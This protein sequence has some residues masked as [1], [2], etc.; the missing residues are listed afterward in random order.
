[1]EHRKQEQL[2]HEILR[3][4]LN[5]HFIDN[6]LNSV[7]NLVSM[8]D[9]LKVNQYLSDFSRL[10]RLFLNN[11]NQEFIPFK[12][13]LES[14]QKY[15]LLEHTNNSDKFEFE[16]MT[17]ESIDM[18]DTEVMPS[19]IQPYIENAIK[20]AFPP[21]INR[22]GKIKIEFIQQQNYSLSCMITDDGIGRKES[23]NH[24]QEL[25]KQRKSKGESLVRDRLELYNTFHKTNYTIVS[26]ELYSDRTEI[27]TKIKIEI[28]VKK[29]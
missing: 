8:N 27:G 3:S 26:E 14:I 20:H 25:Q 2:K 13:E 18:E 11:S 7:N 29:N 19:M 6:C 23:Q 9:E 17:D 15:L 22:K 16:I 28:P 12:D 24:K 21:R 10:M 4:Q 1:M 5:P